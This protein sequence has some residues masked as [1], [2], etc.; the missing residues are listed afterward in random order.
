MI[1][2]ARLRA[3]QF[4]EKRDALSYSNVSDFWNEGSHSSEQIEEMIKSQ[5]FKRFYDEYNIEKL[6][7]SIGERIKSYFR[8]EPAVLT[9]IKSMQKYYE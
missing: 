7:K 2:D 3:Y 9:L 6:N 8:N 4:L 5:T 1:D